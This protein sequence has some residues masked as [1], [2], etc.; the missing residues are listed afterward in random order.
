MSMLSSALR[1][2]SLAGALVLSGAAFAS[3]AEASPLIEIA[4]GVIGDSGHNGRFTG[5][6]A[7]AAYFNPANLSRTSNGINVGIMVINDA[8]S[9]RL[10]ARDVA[11]NDIEREDLTVLFPSGRNLG[12]DVPLPSQYLYQGCGNVANPGNCNL[13]G[14]PRQSQGSSGNTRAYATL[15]FTNKVVE[16]YLHVGFYALLPLGTFTEARAFYADEREQYFSNSLHSELFSDRLMAPSISFGLSSSPIPNLTLGLSFTIALLATADA[17]VYTPEPSALDNSL[18]LS[19]KMGVIAK[20]APH[21]AI[22]YDPVPGLRLSGTVHSPSRF[23]IDMNFGTLLQDSS[24]QVAT[25]R[26]TLDYNPWMF[27][28]G[29][30]YKFDLNESLDFTIV[31]G[32]TYE[33]WSRYVNRQRVVAK[34]DYA[35]SNTLTPSI[36]ARLTN[37]VWTTGLDLKFIPTPIPEQTGRTN[38]VGNHQSL[39]NALVDYRFSLGRLN[40]GVGANAQAHFLHSRRN[41]KIPPRTDGVIRDPGNPLYGQNFNPNLVIDEIPDD[42]V[43]NTVENYTG[44]VG[45]QTNNPGWP[46]FESRGLVWGASAYLSI[47]Y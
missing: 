26:M 35:W 42:T 24:L 15:G 11:V 41:T 36:G 3:Q 47:Y 45:L 25:R 29:A 43:H 9:L 44:N 46:S 10:G 1:K 12:G 38:H 2:H 5:S 27:G 13:P 30:E 7:S 31:G 22:A 32:V 33:L 4:G 6:D 17:T 19:M 20:A 28:L 40:M 34:G 16:D 8:I 18:L 21:F 37:G 23:D 39:A 14:T